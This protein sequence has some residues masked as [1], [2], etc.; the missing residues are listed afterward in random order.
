MYPAK[1]G[2][3]SVFYQEITGRKQVEAA[4]RKTNEALRRA[5]ADLE[6]FAYS[7]SHDLREPLRMVRLYC[8]L[9]SRRYKE[10]LDASAQEMI[11]FCVDG[12]RRMDCLLN[13]LLEYIRVSMP[14]GPGESAEFISLDSCLA[15][16]L[17][18]LRAKIQETGATV[19]HEPLPK[20]PMAAVHAQQLFQ[21]LIGNSL[22]YRGAAA[23]SVHVSARE[24]GDLCVIS[25][26]DNGIGIAPAHH[27][28]VFGVFKRLH[29][30][31]EYSGSGVGLAICKKIV[32]RYGGSI[33]VDSQEGMGSTFSFSVPLHDERAR[34]GSAGP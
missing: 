7:A 34:S 2:G 21:N 18:N 33:W 25:V 15:V 11:S 12:V 16:A 10:A 3:L 9:L 24:D 4:M 8:E 32:E 20:L 27:D 5:N 29:P 23:P 17:A 28:Q 1:D 26:R 14:A 30:A 6:Q 31:S 13:D 22:K 19:T